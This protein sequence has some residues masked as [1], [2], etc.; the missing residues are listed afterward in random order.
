MS[1]YNEEDTLYIGT[2]NKDGS[3]HKIPFET[4][5]SFVTGQIRMRNVQ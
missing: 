5:I 4:Y 1:I 3:P 2:T